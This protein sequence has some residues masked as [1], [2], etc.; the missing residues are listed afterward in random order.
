M[1]K[2]GVQAVVS[3]MYINTYSYFIS[4]KY[5]LI[6]ILLCIY[7]SVTNTVEIIYPKQAIIFK[8]IST[9]WSHL[10]VIYTFNS[11][12]NIF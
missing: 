9:G 7:F 3:P 8:F 10:G 4:S 2:Y 11:S 12:S 1:Y 6:H 5:I